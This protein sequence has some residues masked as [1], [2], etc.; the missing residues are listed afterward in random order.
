MKLK[1]MYW[2]LT[3]MFF[4]ALGIAFEQPARAYTDPGSCL[5]LF[6]SVGAVASG[7]LFYFRRSIRRLL[8]RSTGHQAAQTSPAVSRADS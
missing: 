6:Q 7:A 8:T 2:S 1:L 3:L 5:L 4:V